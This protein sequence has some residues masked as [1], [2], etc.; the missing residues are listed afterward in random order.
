MSADGRE[1]SLLDDRSRSQVTGRP[2]KE[3]HTP[4]DSAV[5]ATLM[6]LGGVSTGLQ[7]ASNAS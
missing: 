1:Q 6:G 2:G 7:L 5:D 3:P 4:L